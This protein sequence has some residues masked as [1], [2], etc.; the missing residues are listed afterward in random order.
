MTIFSVHTKPNQEA[1]DPGHAQELPQVVH[2]VSESEVKLLQVLKKSKFQSVQT[3]AFPEVWW[4]F[5]TLF[6]NSI[7]FFLVDQS[8]I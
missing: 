2:Q 3:R 6:Q 7:T 5:K 4:T 1:A 8:L